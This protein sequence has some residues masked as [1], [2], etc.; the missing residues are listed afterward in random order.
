MANEKP[1]YRNRP[2]GSIDALAQC[3][4]VSKQRLKSISDNAKNSYTEFVRASEKKGV[5]KQRTLNEPKAGLKAIQK[6]IN[7][8]IFEGVVYPDYLHGGL[9]GR[10]YVTNV[11]MHSGAKA[12]IGLDIKDF[13][14]S[15]QRQHVTSIFKN[16]FR[17]PEDVCETLTKLTTKNGKVA[18]GGCCS[19]Y[20]A[21]LIFFNSEYTKVSRFRSKG[22]RYT[23]LLD[24]IT[25]SSKTGITQDLAEELIGEV[26]G[27]FCKFKL[28]LN[29]DK[30]KIE[31]S[32]DHSAAFEITGLWA[33]HG[34]PKL[35]KKDRRYVRQLVHICSKEYKKDPHCK[36]YHALW[37]KTSG[38]VAVLTRLEHAQANSLR[39][40]LGKYLPLY[41]DDA[42]R[43]LQRLAFKLCQVPESEVGSPSKLKVYRKLRYHF[44][45][46]ARN[47]KPIAAHWKKLL[48]E[49][50]KD[51]AE[52]ERKTRI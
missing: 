14:P 9:K 16:L 41:N 36:A 18:Q 26:S 34:E 15:I 33:A 8:E 4:G 46:V 37:N 19:S 5:L 45:I 17:F 49:K 25:I 27:L 11:A 44:G 3:L 23:R 48:D 22:F 6:R 10:D 28:E 39:L 31:R 43:K 30:T 24:D 51:S 47:N 40:E 21:N 50:F 29:R 35:R 38:K 12:L 1:Y 32:N 2:I 13:Y 52:L 20:I 7:R 42:S